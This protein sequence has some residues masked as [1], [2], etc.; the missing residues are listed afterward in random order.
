M[1]YT[2]YLSFAT[3]TGL[4]VL[5]ASISLSEYKSIDLSVSNEDL[6]SI[7]ITSAKEFED[8]INAYLKRNNAKVAY[9]GYLEKRNLYNRSSNFNQ[10]FGNNDR[11]IHLGIDLWCDAGTK[12]LAVL[13]GEIHSFKNNTQ[14]ADYG[15]TIILKHKFNGGE[16]HT[17]YGHLSV[18]SLENLEVGQ[19][20]QQGQTIATLG[21]AEVNGD[22]A[23]HLHFQFIKDMQG[24]FGDYAGVS[25]KTDLEFYKNNCLDPNLLLQL[26]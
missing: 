13:D 9:G 3:K 22:Y 23:P 20:I 21:A 7:D 11:N 18:A 10:N 19:Q 16:F 25:S 15:P 8:Y 6:K 14:I 2:S 26:L 5:D 24:K 4:K 12:V 17:L 1:S